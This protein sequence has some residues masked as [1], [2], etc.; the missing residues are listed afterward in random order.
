MTLAISGLERTFQT[1]AGEQH[2]LRHIDLRVETGELVAFIGHS[3]C[4]KSTLLNLVAGLD[5]P[6]AG[7]ITL[8]GKPVG[9]PGPDR[10]VVFQNLSW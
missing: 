8:D 2:V 5:T 1:K 4:G 9:K 10:A 3:G 6:T 7:S